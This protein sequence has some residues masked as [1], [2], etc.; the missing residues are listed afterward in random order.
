MRTHTG[1]KPFK[2][3]ADFK[4]YLLSPRVVA[5]IEA[6]IFEVVVSYGIALRP[7]SFFFFFRYSAPIVII[8]VR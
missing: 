2:V 5:L 8:D 7:Y 1:E 3:S 4:W 6:I